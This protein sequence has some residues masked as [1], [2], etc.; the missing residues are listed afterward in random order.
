MRKLF[1]LLFT[2]GFAPVVFSQAIST[3]ASYEKT[4]EPALQVDIPFPEKTVANAIDDK[5]S[6]LGYKG[7]S[8]KDYT[9]YK[10]A[11][12]VELG[13]VP[14]DLYFKTAKKKSD[15]KNAATVAMLISTG[16]EK[17]VS[18]SANAELMNNAKLFLDSLVKTV[19]AYDLE[20]QIADQQNVLKKATKK[21]SD[22]SDDGQDLAK[23]EKKLQQEIADNSQSQTSQQAEVAKQQQILATLVNKRQQ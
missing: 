7:S 1:F 18:D 10:G 11:R 19:A 6:K 12:L 3:T 2:L 8:Q 9:L 20:Q 22:L 21:L 23:K 4:Q 15:E 5:I 14:Y 17:F 13:S 16:Y